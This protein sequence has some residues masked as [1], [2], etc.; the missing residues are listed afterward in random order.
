MTNLI[1]FFHGVYISFRQIDWERYRWRNLDKT[2]LLVPL[3]FAAHPID[4]FNDIKYEKRGSLAIANMLL[5]LYFIEEIINYFTVAY[6]F[7]NNEA[8]SFSVWPILLRTVVLVLVWCVTNWATSTLQEGKGNFKEIYLATCYALTPIVLFSVPI[9][10]VTNVLTLSESMF[11]T[12][13]F[14]ALQIW[15]L[16]LVFLGTMVVHQFTVRKTIGS[17]ILSLFMIVIIAFLVLLG[18]SISQQ[19]I[20]FGNTVITELLRR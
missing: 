7:S 10:L 19:M 14:S 1:R 6:L 16:I 5:I 20:T 13:I 3:R 4:L 11:Y 18:F 2:K 9:T 12:A 8:Q 15:S 17:V